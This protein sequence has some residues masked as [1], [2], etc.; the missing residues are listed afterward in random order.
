MHDAHVRVR[1]GARSGR[2]GGTPRPDLTPLHRALH[3]ACPAVPMIASGLRHR[4]IEGAATNSAREPDE[5]DTSVHGV[6]IEA[7]GDTMTKR[8]GR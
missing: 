3:R 8:A 7:F 1:P 6:G 5:E 4:A 2:I